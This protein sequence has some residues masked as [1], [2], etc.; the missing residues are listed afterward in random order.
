MTRRRGNWR[1][2]AWLLALAVAAWAAPT[3]RPAA[4]NDLL[5]D[6]SQDRIEIRYSFAGATLL[7]FGSIP[8]ADLPHGAARHLL[9][10]VVG[11]AKPTVVR[12][13]GRVA[14]I[15]VNTDA[16]TFDQAPGFYFLAATAPLETVLDR[17]SRAA[18]G[19]GFDDLPV[20][21]P[22]GPGSTIAPD[23]AAPFRNALIR[24]NR[25]A[26]L[27]QQRIGGIEIID[28]GLFRTDVPLPA[29]VPVGA[30]TV[31]VF[32]VVDGRVAARK[33]I[34]MRVDKSGFERTIYTLANERP[35]L[36]GLAA[37]VIALVAGWGAGV[38]SRQ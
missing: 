11:P 24:R 22:H 17:G 28:D 4:A 23:A 32:L 34:P 1:G 25:A 30:Y 10:T 26:D 9:V 21:A 29:T 2:V 27:Y 31:T 3:G 12:R 13:K 35:L 38:L 19:I 6:L 15:W 7:L 8:Q 37:V 14:G 16:V 18:L 36:Y 5:A 33:T 20:G